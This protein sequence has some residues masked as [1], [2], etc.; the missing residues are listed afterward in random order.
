MY[1]L[2]GGTLFVLILHSAKEFY[3]G[4]SE[5]YYLAETLKILYPEFQ[6]LEY[7]SV[8][9]SRFKQCQKKSHSSFSS[10]FY[11]DSLR[12]TIRTEINEKY[13]APLKRSEEYVEKIIS[14][15]S[16]KDVLFVKAVIEVI[17]N[18]EDISEETTFHISPDGQSVSKQEL[19]SMN[20][21]YLPSF[22]LGVLYYVMMNIRDNWKGEDTY[23]KWCHIDSNTKSTLRPYKANIGENSSL[24]IELLPKPITE[25]EQTNTPDRTK[26]ETNLEALNH[27]QGSISNDMNETFSKEGSSPHIPLYKMKTLRLE[28]SSMESILFNLFLLSEKVR[29]EYFATYGNDYNAQLIDSYFK[30]NS[31]LKEKYCWSYQKLKRLYEKLFREFSNISL[32]N[33]NLKHFSIP[34]TK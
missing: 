12:N 22:L 26:S 1:K 32:L 25:K 5:P 15:E 24:K 3:P 2:C 34:L 9:T 16:N 19:R 33:D 6:L 20:Q 31:A 8:T 13:E 14:T 29:A 17:L 30:N 4:K 10:V 23:N 27:K 18:D 7:A 28:Y 11:D 21:F